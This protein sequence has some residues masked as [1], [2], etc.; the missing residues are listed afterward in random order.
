MLLSAVLEL[1]V[2]KMADMYVVVLVLFRCGGFFL[3]ILDVFTEVVVA[4]WS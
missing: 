3:H 4:H 1:S 2:S